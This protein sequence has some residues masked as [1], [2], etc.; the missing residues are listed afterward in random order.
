MFQKLAALALITTAL[1][2]SGQIGANAS[3]VEGARA[4]LREIDANGDRQLQF[5]ELAAARAKLF[6]RMDAN[7]N[8]VLDRAEIDTVRKAAKAQHASAPAALF[9]P[10]TI[11][12]RMT[13]IDRNGDGVIARAEFVAFLPAQIRA[14]DANGDGALSIRELR[15]LKRATASAQ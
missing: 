4:K 5:S 3:D 2:V 10:A 13:L 12:E 7:G 8:G 9:D 6:D 15:S 1:Y 11:A 14:A